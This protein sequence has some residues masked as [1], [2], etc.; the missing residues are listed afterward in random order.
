MIV[1]GNWVEEKGIGFTANFSF[2]PGDYVIVTHLGVNYKGRILHATVFIS[3]NHSYEVE[4][5]ND[6]GDFK[7][8]SF[9]PDELELTTKA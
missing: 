6:N 4:Y 8:Q 3:G 5:V 7:A 9:R 2:R 1:P